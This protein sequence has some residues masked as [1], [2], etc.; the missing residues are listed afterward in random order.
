[1]LI[2]GSIPA[3]L[4]SAVRALLGPGVEG[5]REE[6]DVAELYFQDLTW[7][8]LGREEGKVDGG[9]GQKSKVG[10]KVRVDAARKVVLKP[11]ARVKR[12]TRCCALVEDKPLTTRNVMIAQSLRVCVCGDWWMNPESAGP[13]E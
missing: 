7:L 10:R 9:A 11:D 8:G 4:W 6:T 13:M 2:Q 3:V 5:L 1:M 12:C